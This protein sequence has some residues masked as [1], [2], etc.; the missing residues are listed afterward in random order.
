MSELNH[1][2]DALDEMCTGAVAAF[3]LALAEREGADPIEAERPARL[4]QLFCERIA[5]ELAADPNVL[6]G[7]LVHD[8]SKLMLPDEVLKKRGP[9]EPGDW[10]Q[11]RRQRAVAADIL[12]NAPG[13]G[14]AIEIVRHCRERWDGTGYPDRLAGETIPLAARVFALADAFEAITR[15]R[16]YRPGIGVP[17]ALAE[18][19]RCAGTQ[20]DPNLAEPFI[21]LIE[22]LQ[23]T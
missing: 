10:A 9:L 21:T 16:P 13:L 11:L 23:P 8:I 20:F 7:F 17:A 5:P 19:R 12:R 15:G 22:E 4:A 14:R 3:G 18:L 6:R 2:I 1:T